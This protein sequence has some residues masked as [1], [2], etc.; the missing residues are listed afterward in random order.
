MR[1]KSLETIPNIEL[2]N[3]LLLDHSWPDLYYSCDNAVP[4]TPY[5]KID[6]YKDLELHHLSQYLVGLSTSDNIQA[7]NSRYFK[8]ESMKQAESLEQAFSCVLSS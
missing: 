6:G 2:S 5:T 4:I 3:T 8:L 1:V 7:E